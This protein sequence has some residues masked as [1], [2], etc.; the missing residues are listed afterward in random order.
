MHI[1]TIYPCLFSRNKEETVGDVLGFLGFGKKAIKY[2]VALADNIDTEIKSV[3]G[4][5]LAKIITSRYGKKQSYF[6]SCQY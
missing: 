2:N 3:F 1:P 5:D 4:D 6:R